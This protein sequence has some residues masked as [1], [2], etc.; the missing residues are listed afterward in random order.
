MLFFKGGRIVGSEG[1]VIDF[2]MNL[3]D[4]LDDHNRP[5]RATV[6]EM[7]SFKNFAQIEPRTY[8][9]FL[10]ACNIQLFNI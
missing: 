7:V 4:Q 3:V 2:D 6:G 1:M 5:T 9:W 8:T 10:K